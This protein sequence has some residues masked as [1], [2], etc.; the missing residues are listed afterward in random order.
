MLSGCEEPLL[1]TEG[2]WWRR[3]LLRVLKYVGVPRDLT[4]LAFPAL[5]KCSKTLG[6]RQNPSR[7]HWVE[8]PSC[9]HWQTAQGGASGVAVCWPIGA[10]SVRGL[11]QVAPAVTLGPDRPQPLPWSSKAPDAANTTNNALFLFYPL[12]LAEERS[13]QDS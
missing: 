7:L 3:N 2:T 5:A 11:G 9:R 8:I 4:K 1:L 12:F 10:T 6:P 13:T